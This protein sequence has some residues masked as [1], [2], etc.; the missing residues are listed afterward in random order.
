MSEYSIAHRRLGI[1]EA[2]GQKAERRLGQIT[3]VTE[4]VGA[5][6]VTNHLEM[7]SIP[8]Q[9]CSCSPLKEIKL[10]RQRNTLEE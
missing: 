8:N 9:A 4:H 3:K 5:G 7:H 1:R 10:Y 2:L 6:W